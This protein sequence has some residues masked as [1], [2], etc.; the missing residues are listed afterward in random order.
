MPREKYIVEV[1]RGKKWK[2]YS[3]HVNFEFADVNAKVQRESGRE[4]RIKYKDQVVTQEQT[5]VRV[6]E[7]TSI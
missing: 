2:K 4:A 5:E 6:I 7:G 1:K 3:D